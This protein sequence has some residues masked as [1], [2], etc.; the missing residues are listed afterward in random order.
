MAARPVPDPPRPSDDEVAHAAMIEKLFR[1]RGHTLA[2]EQTAS[3]FRASLEVFLAYLQ[4]A[5]AG[6]MITQEQ[7]DGLAA[8]LGA[9][10]RIPDVV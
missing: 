9:A 6:R 8:L 7:S 4:A 1:D 3:V 5:A 10:D 2:D